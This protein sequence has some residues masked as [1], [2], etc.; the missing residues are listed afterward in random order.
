VKKVTK[1]QLARVGDPYVTADGRVIRPVG[2]KKEIDPSPI[3]AVKPKEFKVKRKRTLKDLPAAQNVMHGIAAVFMYTVWG[4]GDREISTALKCDV[5]DVI[6]LR[7]HPAYTELFE[8]V[9]SAFVDANSDLISARIA[10]MS[11]DALT[12]VADIAV[13]GQKEADKLRAS[14]DILNRG[15]HISEEMQN[16]G[17]MSA[18]RILVVDG[19]KSVGVELDGVRVGNG[20]GDAR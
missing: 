7:N 20:N 1:N 14:Q 2:A 3:S 9:S 18:L 5:P 15:G 13:N 10:A 17:G 12:S 19:T 6:S 11:H 4:I 8:A 16:R